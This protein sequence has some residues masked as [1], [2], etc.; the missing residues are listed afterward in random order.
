MKTSPRSVGR[1]DGRFGTT[2]RGWMPRVPC[3]IIGEDLPGFWHPGTGKKVGQQEGFT[4]CWEELQL[5]V[6]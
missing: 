6:A 5:Y 1:L 2:S 3:T 4:I